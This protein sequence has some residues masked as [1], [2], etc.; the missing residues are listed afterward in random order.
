M[1]LKRAL[2]VSAIVLSIACAAIGANVADAQCTMQTQMQSTAT[3][4][5]QQRLTTINSNMQT[6]SLLNQLETECMQGFASVPTQMIGSGLVAVTTMNQIEKSL[7]TSLATTARNTAQSELSAAQ[8][9][10]QA[11]I[12]SLQSSVVS[13]AG[14]TGSLLGNT[15]SSGLTSSTGGV[16]SGLTSSL[17]RLF[18]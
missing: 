10:A 13:S 6:L 4:T 3:A 8:A 18:Q 1:I 5:Q 7:C 12:N 17:A 11:Q 15:T 14:G 9:A 16:L 2:P